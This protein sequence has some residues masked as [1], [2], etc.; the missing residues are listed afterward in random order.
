MKSY[1]VGL[2]EHEWECMVDGQVIAQQNRS[3]E[4]DKVAR[5]PPD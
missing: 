3:A 5:T 2:D 1:W 4:D